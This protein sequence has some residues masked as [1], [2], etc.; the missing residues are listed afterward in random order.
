MLQVQ[1]PLKG[2]QNKTMNGN[3]SFQNTALSLRGA[4]SS[5]NCLRHNDNTSDNKEI[6]HCISRRVLRGHLIGLQ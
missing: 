4:E 2:I 6:A 1:Q 3:R 5:H